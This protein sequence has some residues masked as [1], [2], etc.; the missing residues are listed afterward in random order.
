MI[1]KILQWNLNGFHNNYNELRLLHHNNTPHIVALQETHLKEQ[2]N[3]NLIPKN[4]S[5]YANYSTTAKHGVAFIISNTIPFKII[6]INT[7]LNVLAIEI[8]C[9]I[10]FILINVYLPPLTQLSYNDLINILPESNKPIMVVGDFNAWSPLWGSSSYNKKGKIISQ[11]INDNNF[12]VLNKDSPTHFS[13]HRTFT[14]IDIAFCS[15]ELFTYTS[16]NIHKD[17][18]GSDHYPIDITLF[19]N[20]AKISKKR[21]TFII[22]KAD[23]NKFQSLCTKYIDIDETNNNTSCLAA[24]FQKGIIRSANEAMPKSSGNYVRKPICWWNEKL[25]I[26]NNDKKEK[27]RNF[28]RDKTLNNLM[29]YKRAN[30]LFKRESKI[31]KRLSFI[32][33][34]KD[35]NPN[36]PVKVLWD[37]VRALKGNPLPNTIKYLKLPNNSV[38]DNPLHIANELGQSWAD[39]SKNV[40][41]PEEFNVN[42]LNASNN[43]SITYNLSNRAKHIES[44]ITQIELQACLS[45]LKGK[46]PGFDQI[47]YPMLKN[48]SYSDKVKLCMLYNKILKTGVIPF[49]WKK[50]IVI[51]IRKPNK[52]IDSINGYRP[53]S[54]LSCV[55]KV[56]D[57]IIAR[58]LSWLF[59]QENKITPFQTAYKSE[60]GTINALISLDDYICNTLSSGNHLSIISIDAEKAFDRIG[61]HS[62][63]HQLQ[64]WKVGPIILNY[65]KNFLSNRRISVRLNNEY[66]NT[67]NIENGIPQGSPLSVVLFLIAFNKLSVIINENKYFKHILYADDL[68]I[69]RIVQT[70][71]I[72]NNNINTLHQLIIAWCNYSGVKISEDKCKHLHIC[73]KHNCLNSSV[74]I[75]AS[76]L[77]N[78]VNLKILGI[79][80]NNRYLWNIHVNNLI[81]SLQNRLNVIKSLSNLSLEPN[82]NSL[83][84]I[85]KATILS[86]IDYG[87][88]IYGNTSKRNIT[89][90][91]SCY[92]S[93]IRISL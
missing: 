40:N 13:T 35:I 47:S 39:Y 68:Y 43:V 51:P 92:H 55:S 64:Q 28:K 73:R 10:P 70:F 61:L 58:R 76:R 38:I 72:F 34:T 86:K 44:D 26:L 89:K 1:L 62:I 75:N 81:N 85:V 20:N 65:I 18:H 21:T 79:T 2:P 27:W 63:I 80:F 23:W 9:T 52:P 11:F 54:L 88:P 93:A 24:R 71:D 29:S 8:S 56:L 30:A 53:I 31:S 57:K 36:T 74:S 83:L 41:F 50:A 16:W 33:Y 7:H 5:F 66:S 91:S 90:L 3:R 77:E 32:E 25:N 46:T 6:E 17:L 37:K 4:S 59:T 15:P 78:V 69:Y 82:T 67:F 49:Q 12:I 22:D 19:S 84:N 45:T 48:L 42:K 14:Y 87:L 60:S